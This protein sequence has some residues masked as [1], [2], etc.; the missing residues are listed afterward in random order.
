M[1]QHERSTENPAR[2]GWAPGTNAPGEGKTGRTSAAPSSGAPSG[3]SYGLRPADHDHRQL[4]FGFMA[5]PFREPFAPEDIALKIVRGIFQ[6]GGE[7]WITSLSPHPTRITEYRRNDGAPGI[8][9]RRAVAPFKAGV[10]MTSPPLSMTS[11]RAQEAPTTAQ[12]KVEAFRPV[13]D[14]PPL[15]AQIGPTDHAAPIRRLAIVLTVIVIVIQNLAYPEEVAKSWAVVGKFF[16]GIHSIQRKIQVDGIK[17]YSD[18][19][20]EPNS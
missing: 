18:K 4:A 15:T 5:E 19:A 3:P 14:M 10:A 2:S 13:D 8:R 16:D 9:E 1:E 12:S 7:Q 11:P 20:K 6:D 17:G